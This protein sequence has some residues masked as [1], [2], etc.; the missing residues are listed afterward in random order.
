M[1]R[2]YLTAL[3]MVLALA[4][5]TLTWVRD[6]VRDEL[7]RAPIIRVEHAAEEAVSSAPR[8]V[9]VLDTSASTAEEGKWEALDLR[10]AAALDTLPPHARV[11]VVRYA[12][13]ADCPVPFTELSGARER[14][15]ALFADPA[16]DGGSDLSAGITL[17]LRLLEQR[18]VDDH[19]WI[20]NDGPPNLGALEPAD[21]VRMGDR[22]AE[23]GIGVKLLAAEPGFLPQVFEATA[24]NG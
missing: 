2:W 11:A 23:N 22:A 9:V 15:D 10:L 1:R 19:V 17:A 16:P 12:D 14:L 21:F 8:V 18:G 4:S 5:S 7:R 6:R 24:N 20:V 3:L 13:G